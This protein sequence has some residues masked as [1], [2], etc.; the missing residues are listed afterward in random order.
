MFYA[1]SEKYID[2]YFV[3]NYCFLFRILCPDLYVEDEL[4]CKLGTGPYKIRYVSGTRDFLYRK[5][6]LLRG[7]RV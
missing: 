5:N 3:F 4:K 6:A 7:D 2:L 1:C